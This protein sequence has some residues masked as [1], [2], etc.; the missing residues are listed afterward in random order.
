MYYIRAWPSSFLLANLFLG[1]SR[2]ESIFEHPI[3][4]EN[5]MLPKW[6]LGQ[7]PENRRNPVGLSWPGVN[8]SANCFN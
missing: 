2:L 6:I 1:L 4:A 3:Y 8:I 5:R 7:G